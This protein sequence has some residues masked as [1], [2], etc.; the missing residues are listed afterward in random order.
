MCRQS[1]TS[2]S[3]GGRTNLTGVLAA[4]AVIEGSL[5]ISSVESVA[6]AFTTTASVVDLVKLVLEVG[7]S[8]GGVAALAS[9]DG[10]AVAGH[11]GRVG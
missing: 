10:R 3:S 5:A 4:G 9:E 8:R 11:A 7:T 2:S 1:S 6:A